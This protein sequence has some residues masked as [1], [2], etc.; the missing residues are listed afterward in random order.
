MFVYLLEVVA[1]PLPSWPPAGHA[2]YSACRLGI[3]AQDCVLGVRVVGAEE[4]AGK[5]GTVLQLA[6]DQSLVLLSLY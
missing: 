5:A 4:C 1:V 2:G 6:S 3:Y